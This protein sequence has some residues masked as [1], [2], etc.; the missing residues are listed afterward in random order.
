MKT[1]F[2]L[3]IAATTL[4][5]AQTA[6]TPGTNSFDKK[7][8]KSGK[9][10]M[11]C[12]SL[13]RA[14][15]KTEISTFVFEIN[16]GSGP[17]S[18]YTTLKLPGSDDHWKD[19]SIVDGSSFSPV[20]RSSFNRNREFVLKY[21]KEVTGYY[22][23]KHTRKRNTIKE[24]VKEAFFD[25]YSYP[26]LLG[27]LPLAS[28]YQ[29][30]MTVYDYKPTNTTNIKKTLIQEVKNSLYVSD[31]TGEHKSWQVSVYEQASDERSEYYID[32]ETRR[33]WKVEVFSKGQHILMV[34]KELDF[35]PFK[36]TFDK[37]ATLKMLKSG[38][39]V[40]SGEAF[41]RD[42]QNEGALGGIAVLNINKKQY[43]R[44]G[45]QI[46]LIPYTAFFKEWIKLNEASRKKGRA[47]PLP[48]EVAECMKVTTVYDDK[49]HFEFVNLM[50][51]DYMIYT[52]FGYVH[53]SIRSEVTGYTDTYINGL[54]QGTYA[55]MTTNAYNGNASAAVKKIVTIKK[56]GEKVE[57][58]LK[59]TL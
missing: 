53:T 31:L 55:H 30:D 35:N 48:A 5:K 57:L 42:N 58:K 49:G 38:S 59:K 41:A 45:T 39:A 36:S 17:L 12:F 26:Y 28:G 43:A 54:Y 47:I 50:P 40:I 2:I 18:I 29:A 44:V 22:Y 56:E 15:N 24:P 6:L 1:L 10:E 21:D 19:T 25:N 33:L 7:W 14:G 8:L 37:A 3:L 52:E 23:D 51:G 9:Y 46:V 13:D 32:K 20:Y 11:A 4:C 34:D 16:A 27:L